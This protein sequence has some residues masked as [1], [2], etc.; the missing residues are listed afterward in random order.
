MATQQESR[1][2]YIQ[3]NSAISAAIVQANA[4]LDS[5]PALQ[6]Y[7]GLLE[8]AVTSMSAFIS[9]N[10]RG[11]HGEEGKLDADWLQ[12]GKEAVSNTNKVYVAAFKAHLLSM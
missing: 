8:N 7:I 9:S 12:A 5:A 6:Q 1:D 11:D 10:E 4:A 3:K 2:K